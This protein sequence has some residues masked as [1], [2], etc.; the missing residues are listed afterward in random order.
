MRISQSAMEIVQEDH[1]E[2]AEA[3]KKFKKSFKRNSS[4]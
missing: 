2:I 3:L 1:V 4:K